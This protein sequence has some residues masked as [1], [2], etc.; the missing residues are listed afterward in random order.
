M[1]KLIRVKQ[2]PRLKTS[3]QVNVPRPA[4]CSENTIKRLI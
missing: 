4:G 3:G 1:R 2:E